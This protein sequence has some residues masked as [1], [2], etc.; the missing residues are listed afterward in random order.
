MKELWLIRHGQTDWNADARI[1]GSSDVPLNEV[2]LEQAGCLTQRLAGTRFD[3]VFC[4]DLQRASVT[5]ATAL[6]DAR[7]TEDPRLREMAYGIL[8]GA[9][10]S[11][12]DEAQA[13]AARE[14]REAPLT[15]RIPGGESY[16][17]LT[18]RVR[19]FVDDL[20]AEGRFVA[21]THGGTVRSAL[22][23]LLG[24]TEAVPWR[25]TIHNCS[26]TRL[27]LD[28]SDVRVHCLNDCG[29]LPQA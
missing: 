26:I 1:Q 21:F 13:A 18:R 4:S 28:G 7:A 9:R 8:E 19:A 25:V 11:E 16:D 29:H 14:W 15:R 12:L 3:G 23:S 20:P 27:L 5:C 2:G 22:Y 10:W 24:R 17:D 6:P